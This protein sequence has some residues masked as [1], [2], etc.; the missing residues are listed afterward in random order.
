[1]TLLTRQRPASSF[2][3]PPATTTQSFVY[4]LLGS[5]LIPSEDWE[6]V[7]LRERDK[8]LS[9][10]D[11]DHAL[12]LM[13]EMGLLTHFQAARIST[14]NRFGLVLG[15]FRVLERLGAGGMAVVYKA[16]HIEM[17]HLVAIKVLQQARGDDPRLES[18]FSA[19]MRAVARLRHPNIVAAMDA[20]RCFSP[21]PDG[22]VLWYL[23]ME[24]V[25]GEDLDR[26]VRG[27]GPMPVAQACNI[28]HQIAAALAE[29]DQLRL[30]H[31]DIKPSNVLVTPE[32]VAKLL[33]FGLSRQIANKMTQA[34]T[35]LGTI[36]FMAPEQARDASTADIR[37]DIYGLGGTLFWCL[38]GQVP[39][40]GNGSE[41]ELLVKR[42]SAQPPSL[43]A[44]APGLPEELDAVVRKMMAL[45]PEDRYQTPQE[46]MVA[47]LPFLRPPSSIGL[48]T[49]AGG[50]ICAPMGRPAHSEGARKHRVLVIDDEPGIRRFCRELL[51]MEGI[52]VSEA[53]TGIAGLEAAARHQPDLVLL[54]VILPDTNGHEILKALRADPPLANLK[55]IMFSGQTG[56]DALAGMMLDGADDFLSKPFSVPQFFGR[57][58]TAL[59]LKD[60]QDRS[61]L[62]NHRLLSTNGEMEKKFNVQASGLEEIREA[63]VMALARLVQ[64]R[65]NDGGTRLERMRR[66]SRCLAEE[67]SKLPA[68]AQALSPAFIDMLTACAPL[69]DIGKVGLPDHILLKPGKLAPDE[70]VLMQ[71]HTTVGAQPLDDLAERYP[72]ARA[73]LLM[74]SDVIRHHHERYDGTGYPD[75]LR[76]DA[77]PLS[78]RIVAIA[79]V[80]DALR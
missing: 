53:G 60:A 12:G 52:E 29:T 67:A 39:F 47:L 34:G 13:A 6:R 55:V 65:E 80:Y 76:G 30:V 32:E 45:S 36:D 9:L 54:D 38:T 28:A 10:P 73:F 42:L 23:V 70:R 46:V 57:V 58:K 78:A 35:V 68:F 51:E 44:V 71:A 26:V 72:G 40:P 21:D 33:D 77:I 27:S 1:M 63:L 22:P 79:D 66:Y 48:G 19:E 20:G 43:R 56:G 18:R 61:D 50:R 15:N 11:H 7:P 16:E 4:D 25:P 41:L 2:V 69:H 62:L 74:A 17:R 31:R 49:R 59:R 8:L 5:S 24:Y 14:G 75:R 37:A 3:D 64:M